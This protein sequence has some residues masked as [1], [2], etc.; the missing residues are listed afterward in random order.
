[1]RGCVEN[2]TLKPDGEKSQSR[3]HKDVLKERYQK[4][5]LMIGK[6]EEI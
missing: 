2:V 1:M 6:I 3:Q 4:E 5:I